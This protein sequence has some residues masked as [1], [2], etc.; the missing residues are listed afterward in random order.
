MPWLP[1]TRR[2]RFPVAK[3]SSVYPNQ[4]ARVS[5]TNE[6]VVRDLQAIFGESDEKKKRSSGDEIVKTSSSTTTAKPHKIDKKSDRS[7]DD[8]NAARQRMDQSQ[9]YDDYQ[10][11]KPDM[12]TNDD[13]DEYHETDHD[14]DH[15]REVR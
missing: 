2:K 15:D 7:V 11:D 8:D 9:H 6:K 4:D 10:K 5:G 1:A 12:H 13:N 3:R 14:H